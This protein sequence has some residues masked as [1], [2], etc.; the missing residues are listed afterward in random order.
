[1][2]TEMTLTLS[3]IGIDG[4]LMGILHTAGRLL[5][6]YKNN[7]K[8]KPFLHLS[9]L[10]RYDAGGQTILRYFLSSH[11][12]RVSCSFLFSEDF[13]PLTAKCV[14]TAAHIEKRSVEMSLV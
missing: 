8:P 12:S 10:Y 6:G 3:F 7:N 5:L 9:L 11:V 14:N 1:M 2:A 4:I 13:A